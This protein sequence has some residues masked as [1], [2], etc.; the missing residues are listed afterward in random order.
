LP[1][2]HPSSVPVAEHHRTVTQQHQT[3]AVT[4]ATGTIGRALL[5]LLEASPRIEKVIALASRPWDPGAD[6]YRKVDYRQVDVR[7]QPAVRRAFLGANAVVHLAFSLYGLRQSDSNLEE[8]NVTGS[9]NVLAAAADVGARRFVYT[10]SAAVYGFSNDRPIRVD[11]TASV[12]RQPR[13]FYA[14][15]KAKVE[16]ALI[17][18]LERLRGL[19]WTFFRPC[20]VVGPNAIGAAGHLLP[21]R[22]TRALAALVTIGGAAGLRPI[23]PAP[24]VPV[25]FVHERDVGQAIVRAI[26]GNPTR[27]TYNLAGRGLVEPSEIPRLLGLRTLPM[28]NRASRLAMKTAARLPYATPALGWSRLLTH[29]LELDT[30]RAESELGW[31]PEFTSADALASTRRAL[32]L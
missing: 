6:G 24:P 8:V 3:V 28:S 23:V 5:P 30:S 14:R 12:E 4:G 31:Q 13:H 18:R 7:D 22:V 2:G 15:H 20:A 21:R 1:I 27:G 26:T 17:P 10:S 25:Q 16:E 32:G 11:E 9:K 19:D 29:P